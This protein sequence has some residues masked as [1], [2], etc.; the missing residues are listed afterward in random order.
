MHIVNILPVSQTNKPL[1]F[2]NNKYEKNE[3]YKNKKIH[4]FRQQWI[5][6]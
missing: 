4:H 2:M 3:A 5:R 6:Y 1:K